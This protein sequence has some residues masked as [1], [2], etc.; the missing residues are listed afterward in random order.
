MYRRGELPGIPD[1]GVEGE[2]VRAALT[3]AGHRRILEIGCGTGRLV[4]LL[5]SLAAG[6]VGL[7]RDR[8]MLRDSRSRFIADGASSFV[9]GNALRLPFRDGSYSA[10]VMVRV[11]HR[12][13]DPPTA[14]AEARRMIAPGGKMVLAVFP[15]PSLATLTFD[16]WRAISGGFRRPGL[17]FAREGRVEIPNGSHDGFVETLRSTYARLND[18]GFRVVQALGCGYED[19]PVLR[20]LPSA[21]WFRLARSI[22]TPRW[23]PCV[24]VV[25]EP[26]GTLGSGS[27]S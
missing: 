27:T 26:T 16:I 18:A 13:G 4:P 11:Y 2:L 19:L 14:L 7:D 10:V 23:F 25:A 1:A 8:H 22:R 9:R 17:T 3:G 5:R 20:R 6:Y 24:V 12:L 21:F 15:R